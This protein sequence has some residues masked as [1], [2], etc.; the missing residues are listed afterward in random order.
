VNTP[1]PSTHTSPNLDLLFATM[2]ARKQK[3]RDKLR[4]NQD[5]RIA[6]LTKRRPLWWT[7]D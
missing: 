1:P 2:E 5:A 4:Q 3:E 6:Q 7:N